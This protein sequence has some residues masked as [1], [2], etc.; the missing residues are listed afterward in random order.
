MSEQPQTTTEPTDGLTP[1]QQKALAALLR[2]ATVEAAAKSADIG[3]STLWTWLRQDGAFK[4]AYE[5]AQKQVLADAIASLTSASSGA[6]GV[7]VGLMSD[8]RA[9][10]SVRV[11]AASKILDFGLKLR[12][13][14]QYEERLAAIE[15]A[16]DRQ[17]ANRAKR[18]A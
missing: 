9:A 7:L 12:E 15:E 6:V 2:H 17:G 10:G 14:W 18:K 1:K 3:L 11:S 13:S 16:L 5:Q 4:S 8:E